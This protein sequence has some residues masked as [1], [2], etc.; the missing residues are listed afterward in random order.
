MTIL[1]PWL[2]SHWEVRPAFF[3]LAALRWLGCFLILL[4]LS[5]LLDAFARF[6]LYG[7]GTPAP[8]MPTE[9]LVITGGYRHVRN[10]MYIAILSI[11]AGEALLLGQRALFGY[12]LILWISFQIF[13]LS[14][15]EPSL[16][17]R[18]GQQYEKY[19]TAVRRWWPRVRPWADGFQEIT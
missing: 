15:E 9:R 19:C 8:Y 1:F 14:Y 6:T 2:L 3:G 17:R 11:V 5:V 7:R 13:V 10:P 18:Y 4:G 16:R 12:A